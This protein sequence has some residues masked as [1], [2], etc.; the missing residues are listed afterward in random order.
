EREES[1]IAKLEAATD[2]CLID[3][4]MALLREPLER[5]DSLSAEE[6]LAAACAVWGK[7]QQV[8]GI[9]DMKDDPE[10]S[11]IGR[12]ALTLLEKAT[13]AVQTS[14]QQNTMNSL[15]QAVRRCLGLGGGACPPP[16][17]SCRISPAPTP[18]VKY[19]TCGSCDAASSCPSGQPRDRGE[20]FRGLLYREGLAVVRHLVLA[21]SNSALDRRQWGRVSCG[22][23]SYSQL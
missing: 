6:A 4:M 14:Q 7:L 16:S 9:E 22:S 21:S 11:L 20:P 13:P 8:H 12:T 17:P 10:L 3:E 15:L 23:C 1:R 5:I 2:Q 18:V 19:V